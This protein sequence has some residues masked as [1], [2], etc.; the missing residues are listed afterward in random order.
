L[1]V[2]RDPDGDSASSGKVTLEARENLA[3]SLEATSQQTMWVPI[4]G[5]AG[6]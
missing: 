6:P 2:L 4:L 1:D 5:G 3:E